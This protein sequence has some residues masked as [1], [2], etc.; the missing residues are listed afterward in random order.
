[1]ARK[2]GSTLVDQ[3][4]RQVAGFADLWSR[5]ER[6]IVLSGQSRSTLTCYGRS[7]AQMALHFKRSPVEVDS[8]E[9]Q[10]YLYELVRD[11]Q[12]SESYFKFS[13]YA[14]RYAYRILGRDDQRI[15]LPPIPHK[16]QLPTVLS[17]Q[18][19]RRLFVAPALL[20]HRVLLTFLYS[21]G[22]RMNEARLLEL[23]DIDSDRMQIH[24]RQGKGR[25]DRYVTLST[26]MLRGLRQYYEVCKPKRYLFNGQKPGEPLAER[27]MQWVL[28]QAVRKAGLSKDITLHTLRH[29][30]ATHLLE[31]GVDLLTIKEQLGH[32]RIETTMVYLHIARVRK[33]LPHSPLDTLYTTPVTA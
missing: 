27:A 32:A 12:F 8:E 19:C 16:N 13:V 22:L 3:A 1:M 31:D 17:K 18:E 9:L 7:L 4:S 28:N 14:L 30:F 10:Q 24:V 33:S 6:Q 20:K 2:K 23:K 5:V 11:R 26:L 21:S 29:S 15:A 25:K